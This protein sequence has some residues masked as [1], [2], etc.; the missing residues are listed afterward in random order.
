MVVS[1]LLV[2]SAPELTIL[3][4]LDEFQR[5]KVI[6]ALALLLVLTGLLM[7]FIRATARIV[8]WYMHRCP[9]CTT[10]NAAKS[11]GSLHLDRRPRVARS[12]RQ[13]WGRPQ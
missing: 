2:A 7:L 11:L 8:R 1:T 5:L 13:H 10:E 9:T 4:R 6:A 12:D 3:Q